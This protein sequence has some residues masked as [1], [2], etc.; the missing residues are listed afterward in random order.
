[1][2]TLRTS[3]CSANQHAKVYVGLSG[4]HAHQSTVHLVV[5]SASDYANTDG[6]S[7]V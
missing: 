7:K 3:Y 2:Q 5:N 6:C 4:T 1:M